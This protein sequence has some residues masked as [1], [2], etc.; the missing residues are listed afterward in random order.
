MIQH[1]SMVLSTWKKICY[2]QTLDDILEER[3][4]MIEDDNPSA[5]KEADVNFKKAITTIMPQMAEANQ[6]VVLG[7]IRDPSGLVIHP[8]T[9]EREANLKLLMPLAE[10][11]RGEEVAEELASIQPLTDEQRK[12][13]AEMFEDMEIAHEHTAHS[14]SLLAILSRSLNSTQLLTLLRASIRLLVQLNMVP[15]LFDEPIKSQQ[16]M[17]L[18]DDK[19]AQVKIT[20]IPVATSMEIAHEKPNSMMCL[21]AATFA[22]KIL[23]KYGESATQRELQ[24]MYQV[25]P[26][27]LALCIMGHRYWGSADHRVLARKQKAADD[28]EELS[29]SEKSAAQ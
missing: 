15:G 16:R 25:R 9:E 21:L 28:D 19:S 6:K 2:S 14:C 13:I 23:K 17:G 20:M 27:Q 7:A 22:F 4:T 29:T 8:R 1:P 5:M 11:P 10:I 12:Q 24:L 18:P 3:T 26:K